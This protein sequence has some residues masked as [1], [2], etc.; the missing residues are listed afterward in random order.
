M[1]CVLGDI[2]A[3]PNGQ[4]VNVPL[5]CN[6]VTDE[7]IMA[8]RR[9]LCYDANETQTY[10]PDNESIEWTIDSTNGGLTTR[11]KKWYYDEHHIKLKDSTISHIGNLASRNAIRMKEV[12]VLFTRDL[13]KSR[14]FFYH[15]GSC[16]WSE[17]EIS[18]CLMKQHGGIGMVLY[19]ADDHDKTIGR[20]W[21][22]PLAK[23]QYPLVPKFSS[24]WYPT[25]DTDTGTFVLFNGYGFET[26]L[27]AM[28]LAQMQGSE[29]QLVGLSAGDCYINNDNGFLIG[30]REAI[31]DTKSV[32]LN[33]YKECGCCGVGGYD[34]D[35]YDGDDDNN[36]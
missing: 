33:W 29:Y 34:G 6:R 17:Y 8:I 36:Y 16:W 22:V 19:D 31:G 28:L 7:G 26:R 12:G 10:N 18:R 20:A 25:T 32:S 5:E 14:H 27:F 15:K 30:S 21:L 4:I 2:G 35:D 9:Y 11:I 1:P 24:G 3:I 13:N 23:K